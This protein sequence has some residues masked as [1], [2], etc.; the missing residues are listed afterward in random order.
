MSIKR[1]K[2]WIVFF[3]IVNAL[4][5]LWALG[6]HTY[7]LNNFLKKEDIL[8]ISPELPFNK[9][10]PP[11]DKSFPNENSKLWDG[12]EDNKSIVDKKLFEE[13]ETI[14]SNKKEYIIK[15]VDKIDETS[16]I[17]NTNNILK[18]ES[19]SSNVNVTSKTDEKIINNEKKENIDNSKT[20]LN[21][22]L[23][24]KNTDIKK[25]NSI[26]NIYYYVQIASVSQKDLVEKEWNRLKKKYSVNFDNLSYVVEEVKLKNN[27]TFFRILAKEFSEKKLAE[28]FCYKIDLKNQCLIKKINK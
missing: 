14:K 2:I 9:S 11:K 21:R 15:E 27:Q 23:N 22:S 28:N 24:T 6:Y 16:T 26:K 7:F 17:S 3:I 20:E 5:L 8:I 13:N 19:S 1:N 4:L 25:N 18:K 10:L 12:F